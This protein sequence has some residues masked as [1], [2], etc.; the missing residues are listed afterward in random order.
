MGTT[1]QRGERSPKIGATRE[2]S[3][4]KEIPSVI[5]AVVTAVIVVEAEA[6]IRIAAMDPVEVLA[7]TVIV[8][9]VTAEVEAAEAEIEA[10]VV[11]DEEGRVLSVLLHF[12][13]ANK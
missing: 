12:I 13:I 2:K 6:A 8:V 10:V 1:E 4:Q 7:G 11:V 3:N 9:T 5:A